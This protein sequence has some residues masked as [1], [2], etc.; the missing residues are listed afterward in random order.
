MGMDQDYWRKRYSRRSDMSV[1][2]AHLTRGNTD[3]ES[4][5]TLWKILS[6]RKLI[7]NSGFVKGNNK[8]CCFQDIPVTAIAENLEYEKSI[9]KNN[10]PT[11]YAPFGIRINKAVLFTKGGR[12][13]IYC[14]NNEVNEVVKETNIWRVVEMQYGSGNI[15]DWSHEREWRIK[16]D[17]L[18]EYRDIDIIVKDGAYYQKLFDRCFDTNNHNLLREVNGIIPIDNVLL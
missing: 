5:E 14:S 9:R 4:F 17:M 11:R 18:F 8:V 7:A 3:D 13:V 2:V 12:P 15:I 6:E 10:E 16:G 1:R